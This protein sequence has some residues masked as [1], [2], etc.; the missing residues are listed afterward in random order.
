MIFLS[1]PPL[2]IYAQSA[3]TIFSK[4][5]CALSGKVGGCRD[6]IA[7]LLQLA[8]YWTAVFVGSIKE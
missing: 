1:P 4:D 6:D 5:Q 3:A 2:D 7:I 8:V